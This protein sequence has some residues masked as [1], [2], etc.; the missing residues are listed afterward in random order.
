MTRGVVLFAFNS[1]NYDYYRMAEYTANRINHF[2][3]LPV[4]VITNEKS[5][6]S[7]SGY[8]FDKV[9]T[10]DADP[11][12]NFRNIIWI[13][14]GRYKAYDLSPYDETL[15]LDSDYMVNSDKLNKVFDV[16]DDFAC[17]DTTKYL[18]YTDTGEET[19]GPHSCNTLWAT[20]IG[21]R[22]TKRVKQMFECLE[23]VQKNYQHYANIHGFPPEIYRNDYGLTLAHRIVNGHSYPKSDILPW[24]LTHIGLKTYV[25]H[26]HPYEYNTNYTILFDKWNRGKLK[27]EYITIKDTDFH[28]I[29]KDIF[30]ELIQ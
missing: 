30:V 4:T 24:S 27:K 10:T 18:M 26:N 20:V 23:M 8:K 2:L 28:V 21:F 19:L 11:T 6:L 14:K 15:V 17:H 9:I 25:Y 7:S 29:N 22:K 12:N 3:G 1:P 5:L 16:M 13:N